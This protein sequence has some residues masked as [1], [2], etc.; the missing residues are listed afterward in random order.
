MKRRVWRT[1]KAGSIR[2]LRLV[3]ETLGP[4]DP[5]HVRVAVR[6]VGLNFADLF[7]LTLPDGDIEETRRG[8]ELRGLLR[9]HIESEQP[10]T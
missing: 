10:A 4:L 8:A 5:D 6:A 2:R 3:E 1:K 9:L 7:A